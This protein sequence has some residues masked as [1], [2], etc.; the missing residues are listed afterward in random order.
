MRAAHAD[1]RGGGRGGF[2]ASE[3]AFSV[4][5]MRRP[6]LCMGLTGTAGVLSVGNATCV[7]MIIVIAFPVDRMTV[8][9]VQY[10]AQ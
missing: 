1:R 7:G 8:G 5:R 2:G 4:H 10:A 3:G 9:V 6:G